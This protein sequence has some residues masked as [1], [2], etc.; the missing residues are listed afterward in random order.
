MKLL[1]I[2][3]GIFATAMA[4]EQPLQPIDR[5]VISGET[6][7]LPFFIKT[8]LIAAGERIIFWY[9]AP[10]GS[11]ER[12][13]VPKTQTIVQ[14]PEGKVTA[15]TYEKT[16]VDGQDGALF[17]LSQAEYEK[18]RACLPEPTKAAQ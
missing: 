17:R 13:T 1:F 18:D 10:N 16:S 15:P 3:L 14:V 7:C 11:T 2:F 9:Q 8:T 4:E 5:P 6:R 12:A